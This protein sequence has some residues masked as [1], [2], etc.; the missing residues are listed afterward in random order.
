M[1]FYS[2]HLFIIFFGAALI[3]NSALTPNFLHSP[4]N[5]AESQQR[6]TILNGKIISTVTR[7]EAFPFDAVIT[8]VLVAPGQQVSKDDILIKYSLSDD[9]QRALDKE[10]LLG[11]GTEDTSAQILSL[12]S[13]LSKLQAES[14]TARQLASAGLGSS[15]AS[16][17]R[18]SEVR[19]LEERITLLRQTLGKEEEKFKHRLDEL[20]DYYGVPIKSKSPLPTELV[21]TSPMDGHVLS[22]A[23]TA[24]VGALLSKGAKPILIGTMDP[25]L[26]QIQVFEGELGSIKV[27]DSAKV[28][29]PSLQDKIFQ[30]KV[31]KIS[32][33]SSDLNVAAASYFTV[34]LSIPNPDL[35]LKPGFKAIVTFDG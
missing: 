7:A 16:V 35:E 10:M 2:K 15:K 9:A 24:Q 14:N 22:V 26:I 19:F 13:E 12:Q 5:A 20:S 32:W 25:M 33:T 11:A 23:G 8:E 17:R 27:G 29:I 28:T 34:E 4:V 31:A 18:A 30:A 21:L 3:L 6:S 1:K